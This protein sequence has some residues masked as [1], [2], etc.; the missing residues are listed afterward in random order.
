M[1]QLPSC[2]RSS[3]YDDVTDC[4]TPWELSLRRPWP[5][6][7]LRCAETLS[8]ARPSWRNWQAGKLGWKECRWVLICC[9]CDDAPNIRTFSL[10]I[11]DASKCLSFRLS[12][13][14]V[15]DW[16]WRTGALR[17]LY[18]LDKKFFHVIHSRCHQCVGGNWRVSKT[19]IQTTSIDNKTTY[20]DHEKE[21]IP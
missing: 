7:L 21:I 18:V 6:W 11:P 1:I 2:A 12:D 14:A 19:T 3:N 8:R 9:W 17:F 20:V 4:A 16:L 5:S 15:L 13:F 10:K